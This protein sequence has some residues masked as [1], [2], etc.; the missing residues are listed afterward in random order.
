MV[1]VRFWIAVVFFAF[2]FPFVSWGESRPF[3][4]NLDA[5]NPDIL[6]YKL[7]RME[8]QAHYF[9]GL[10]YWKSGDCDSAIREFSESYSSDS[11]ARNQAVYL[12]RTGVCHEMQGHSEKAIDD[13]KLSVKRGNIKAERRLGELNVEYS[14]GWTPLR[15][16]GVPFTPPHVYGADISL[17]AGQEI[18]VRGIQLATLVANSDRANGFQVSVSNFVGK[19]RVVQVGIFNN[20][21]LY[22]KG[23]G[24]EMKG[25]IDG[26]QVGAINQSRR[27]RGSQIGLGNSSAE[28]VGLQMAV[29]N[30]VISVK[31][32]QCAALF[33]IIA[34]PKKVETKGKSCGVQIAP[35]NVSRRQFSGLQVGIIN[36]AES[37]KGLQIGLLNIIQHPGVFPTPVMPL[38]N[39]SW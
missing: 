15:I 35:L 24:P 22:G 13:Y 27:T 21:D 36:V 12:Y 34:S 37:L 6:R 26:I 17:F 31:G 28:M 20:F 7:L 38:V 32:V 9:Q 39:L 1:G 18:D 30:V 10:S 4:P 33:N 25:F 19:G 16:F 3:A 11:N 5:L 29:E 14:V 8:S 23:F 2:L